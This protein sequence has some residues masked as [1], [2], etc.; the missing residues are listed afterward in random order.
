MWVALKIFEQFCAKARN[1]NSLIAESETD[2]KAKWP[3]EVI[4]GHLFGCH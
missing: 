1:T 2:F 4:Q 3:F